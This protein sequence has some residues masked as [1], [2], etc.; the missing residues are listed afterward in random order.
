MKK[1][2][3]ICCLCSFQFTWAQS[4]KPFPGTSTDLPCPVGT[5]PMITFSIEAFNFH[6]P[7]TECKLGF[8]LCIKLDVGITC[9]SCTGKSSIADNK[10][11]AWG[12]ILGNT[13]ELHIPAALQQVVG[14][15]KTDMRSFQLDEQFIRLKTTNGTIKTVAGGTYPVATRENE[16]VINLP[17]Y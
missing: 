14:F 11:T 9:A 17:L 1:I 16:L 6:K 13:L 4:S 3:F 15:E 2:L 5:C 12:K 10:V 7:R 8:G